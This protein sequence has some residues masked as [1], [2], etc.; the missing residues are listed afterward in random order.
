MASAAV[1]RSLIHARMVGL[2]SLQN[3]CWWTPTIPWTS[4]GTRFH[5]ILVLH[6][7]HPSCRK[8]AQMKTSTLLTWCDGRPTHQIG[9]PPKTYLHPSFSLRPS[10][11]PYRSQRLVIPWLLL[12]PQPTF[13]CPFY[14][15]VSPNTRLTAIHIKNKVS[16]THSKDR[17]R[18]HG[19]ATPGMSLEHGPTY[20]RVWSMRMVALY[21]SSQR[22]PR[23]DSEQISKNKLLSPPPSW[24]W[25]HA[26][27]TL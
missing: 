15:W 4:G 3:C 25:K 24:R 8:Q 18:Q 10:T 5:M 26:A 1:W 27:S 23:K 9:S 13:P 16:H 7:F 17:K 2:S 21:P 14:E 22:T 6:G 12:T 11:S 19:V 20:A